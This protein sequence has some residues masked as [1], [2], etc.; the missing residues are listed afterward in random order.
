MIR[1]PYSCALEDRN[2]TICYDRIDGRWKPVPEPPKLTR[3]QTLQA[4]ASGRASAV[5]KKQQINAAELD[6]P[7][8]SYCKTKEW[9]ICHTCNT[10]VCDSLT[11]AGVFFNCRKSCGASGNLTSTLTCDAIGGPS[12]QKALGGPAMRRLK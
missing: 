2:Y 11:A 5:E 1:I 7:A 12:S 8:C 6:E 4:L 9:I 3:M 10:H